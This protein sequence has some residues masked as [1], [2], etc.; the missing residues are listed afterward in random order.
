[1]TAVLDRID[2]GATVVVGASGGPDSAGLLAFVCSSRPDL[3]VVAV[4]VRH[5]LRDDRD[6]AEA[7]RAQASLLG[8][9]FE[10]VE[11]EVALAGEGLEAAARAARHGALQSSAARVGAVA[12]LLGHTVDDQAETVLLRLARGTTLR[13]AAGMR[14]WRSDDGGV[15]VVRPL[16]S[17]PRD[18]VHKLAVD[19]GLPVANDPTNED[20]TFA[21]NVVRGTVL[22]GLAVH[23]GDPGAALARFAQRAAEDDDHL[24]ALADSMVATHAWQDGEAWLVPPGVVYDQPG[25]IA[26]RVIEILLGRIRPD[27]GVVA[28]EVDDVLHLAVDRR[29]DRRGV[30]V[31]R[32]GRSIRFECH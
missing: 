7:A 17:W 27:V 22:P 30:T 2:H 15:P 13:G 25:A 20:P 16:L 9:A 26:R 19:A 14:E 10:V 4:H 6:D 3:E 5:G 24:R 8:A 23:A 1:M 28:D 21:R 29:V 12:V 11:V 18:A 31:T 32:H